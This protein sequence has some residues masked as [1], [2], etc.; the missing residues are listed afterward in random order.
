MLYIGNFSYNDDSDDKDNFCLM[1]C[2][3]Y[4]QNAEEAMGKF[5]QHFQD[6]RR[7]T[8][9][10]DGAHEIYLDSLTELEEAPSDPVICQW[11]KIVPAVNGLCSMTSVLPDLNEGTDMV[12]ANACDDDEDDFDSD[13]DDDEDEDEDEEDEFVPDEPFLS[14]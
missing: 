6:F 10:L 4:A 8:D 2:V 11:Q 3:V 9:L 12:N 7:T 13:Q 1:P 5:A 14:F